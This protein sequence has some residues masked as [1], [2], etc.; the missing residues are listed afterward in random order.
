MEDRKIAPVENNLEKRQTYREQMKRYNKAIKEGFY[1]EALLIDY[2]M[3]ED[4][5]RS[6]L[7]HVAFFADRNKINSWKKTKPYFQKFVSE[8][9]NPDE[10]ENLGVSTSISGKI[11][12][13]RSMLRWTADS[14]QTNETDRYL[15]TLKSQLEGVDI[16]ALLETL[17][18]IEEWRK[19]R[20]EIVHSLLNK[21]VEGVNT[22]LETLAVNGMKYAREID[23]QL[24]VL[25]KGNQIRRSVNAPLDK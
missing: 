18:N 13:I 24:K 3:L 6:V 20:N 11:K 21:S 17:E 12:N 25:K 8:Y 1:F 14:D 16:G 4:R 23:N 7:Y 9:K 10:N 2:A 15:L 19:Y 22:E 5:L